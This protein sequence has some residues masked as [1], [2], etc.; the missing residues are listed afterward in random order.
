MRLERMIPGE[1][2]FPRG[3]L[4][5]RKA[6]LVTELANW[7]ST[8]RRRRRRLALVLVPAS[9]A[10]LAITGF[11][12]YTLTREPTVFESVGCFET[13]STS[14]NVAVVAADGRDPAVICGEIFKTGGFPGVSAPDK[15][16]SCVLD[17]GAIG[18]FPKSG[19]N[20]CEDLGLAALPASY[21]VEGKRFATLRDAIV[22]QVGEPASGSTRGGPQCVGEDEARAIVRREL[23]SHGYGDWDVKVAG[24][25]FSAE[26]PCAD[27]AF[28]SAGKT[29]LLLGGGPRG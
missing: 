2:D 10:L 16:A 4:A 27:V 22:A 20:T 15:L 5:V 9:L 11:T 7:N 8:T 18:V 28:D 6:Q 24:E 19:A 29:V 17:S 23:D 1:R 12:T 14:A 21:A 25:G 26:R 3:Q 13:A